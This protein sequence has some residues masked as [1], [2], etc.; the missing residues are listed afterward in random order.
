MNNL[1]IFNVDFN[2]QNK[3]LPLNVYA[4]RILDLNKN[5]IYDISIEHSGYCPDIYTERE[6]SNYNDYLSNLEKEVVNQFFKSA[7]IRKPK[8]YSNLFEVI[9]NGKGEL[10]HYSKVVN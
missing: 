4:L 9:T 1:E 5:K 10:Y 7:K 3:L 8:N 2:L 6:Q